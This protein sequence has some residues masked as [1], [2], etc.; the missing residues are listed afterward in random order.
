MRIDT[1]W[2]RLTSVFSA[3]YGYYMSVQIMAESDMIG[4]RSITIGGIIT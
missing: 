4:Q 3:Y 1:S 2:L